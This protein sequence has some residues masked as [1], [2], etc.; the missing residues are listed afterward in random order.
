MRAGWSEPAFWTKDGRYDPLINFYQADEWKTQYLKNDFHEPALTIPH[1]SFIFLIPD[2]TLS[3]TNL[4]SGSSLP[5][6]IKNT[7]NR[8][9]L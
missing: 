1:L 6:K 8:I 7:F 9:L 5:V 3:K 2:P 4:Y